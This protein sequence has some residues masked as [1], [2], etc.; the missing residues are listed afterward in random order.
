M[1]THGLTWKFV[2]FINVKQ[3]KG[4]ECSVLKIGGKN[5]KWVT[6][7]WKMD[8]QPFSPLMGWGWFYLLNYILKRVL[9]YS[10][11]R[12][13]TSIRSSDIS[14]I[15]FLFSTQACSPLS[16]PFQENA[17]SADLISPSPTPCLSQHT[18][19]PHELCM[20]LIRLVIRVYG[21]LE[22]PSVL[23]QTWNEL[24]C[25]HCPLCVMDEREGPGYLLY[26]S[27]CCMA[28]HRGIQCNNKITR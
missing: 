1:F 2:L 14:Y 28:L 21:Q 4:L 10:V 13:N 5:T 12:V 27:G 11:S 23:V 25:R 20:W 24:S 7:Y 18:F 17:D 8:I 6:L 19:L 15:V 22:K 16:S 9:E 26:P 3:W